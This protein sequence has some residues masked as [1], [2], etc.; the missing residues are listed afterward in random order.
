MENMLALLCDN[1]SCLEESYSGGP[2][3]QKLA[4][5]LAK[6]LEVHVGKGLKSSPV[7]LSGILLLCL[8]GLVVV[9]TGILASA[10]Q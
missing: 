1:T 6:T 10:L 7:P 2:E 8:F 9:E 3:P 5:R 4:P